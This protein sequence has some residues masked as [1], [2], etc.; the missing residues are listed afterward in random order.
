MCTILVNQFG[1]DNMVQ[2]N[3]SVVHWVSP[4]TLPLKGLVSV[5]L[6]NVFQRSLLCSHK[7]AFIWSIIQ[8]K[9]VILW[10]FVKNKNNCFKM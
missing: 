6:C 4:D 7:A 9:I 5:W 3:D 8:K 1:H 2:I 10:I